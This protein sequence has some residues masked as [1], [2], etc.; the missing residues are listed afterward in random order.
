[1]AFLI[2]LEPR[3]ELGNARGC[4]PRS[5]QLGTVGCVS[6]S[7]HVC[8]GALIPEAAAGVAAFDFP[9]CVP[10]VAAASVGPIYGIVPDSHCR[11]SPG[12][13]LPAPPLTCKHPI[14]LAT[15]LANNFHIVELYA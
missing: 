15:K 10:V 1:M 9:V 5:R 14:P 7:P 6:S 8:Q 4:Q 3:T 11:G 12:S 2:A 13:A